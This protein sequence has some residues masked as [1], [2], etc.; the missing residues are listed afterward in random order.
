MTKTTN[1]NQMK[2]VFF[3]NTTCQMMLKI[4]CKTCKEINHGNLIA[5]Q[6]VY[7]THSKKKF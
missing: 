7:L 2:I 1:E 5:F 6:Q 3:L 4:L